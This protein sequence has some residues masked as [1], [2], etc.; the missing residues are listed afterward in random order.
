MSNIFDLHEGQR[1]IN[2][3]EFDY[4]LG[5]NHYIIIKD[6]AWWIQ[7]EVEIYQWMELNLPKGRMHH[8]GMVISIPYEKMVTAFLLTWG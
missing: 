2:G 6:F 8:E 7:N 1:F 3:G 4:G 5:P